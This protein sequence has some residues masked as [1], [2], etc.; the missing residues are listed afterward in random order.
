MSV[1][2][3]TVIKLSCLYCSNPC[4]V[5]DDCTACGTWSSVFY[6]SSAKNV[7][8]R[9]KLFEVSQLHCPACS[10]LQNPL[11]IK[12]GVTLNG[13]CHETKEIGF[14]E[15]LCYNCNYF[16]FTSLNSYLI[17]HKN[18]LFLIYFNIRSIQKNIQGGP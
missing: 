11:I 4:L 18:K 5:N 10:A 1:A 14:L 8:F 17:Y 7:N 16:N 9:V 6:L 13:L 3:N 15:D 2:A 12:L